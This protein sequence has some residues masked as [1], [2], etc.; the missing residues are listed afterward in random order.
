MKEKLEVEYGELAL[1]MR[2]LEHK[3]HLQTS[4]INVDSAGNDF[5]NSH[6]SV[7]LPLPKP[8]TDQ[9]IRS[10]VTGKDDTQTIR[11][12]LQFEHSELAVLMDDLERKINGVRDPSNFITL[13]ATTSA[14]QTS[15]MMDTSPSQG[16]QCLNED[17]AIEYSELASLQ[18]KLERKMQLQKFDATQANQWMNPPMSKKLVVRGAE[19]RSKGGE[20]DANSSRISAGLSVIDDDVAFG[21]MVYRQRMT[22]QNEEGYVD[23]ERY[24]R[25]SRERY[26]RK[27]NDMEYYIVPRDFEKKKKKRKRRFVETITRVVHDE[28]EEEGSSS[29]VREESKAMNLYYFVAIVCTYFKTLTKLNP[30][31]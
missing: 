11:E 7:L 4:V 3:K 30:I 19:K 20:R 10:M 13:P 27:R 23:Q 16:G 21:E 29:I 5:D 31:P 26:P 14:S 1:L 9:M 2:E 28:S 8:V 25:R 15:A 22:Q 17:L 12:Q 24:S 18:Q 6:D